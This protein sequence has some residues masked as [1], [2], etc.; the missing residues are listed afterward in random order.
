MG[1]PDAAP[2]AGRRHLRLVEALLFAAPQPL[3]VADIAAR[4]PDDAEP[5]ALLARLRDH[6]RDRGVILIET[7][8]RWA[9]RT[10]PDLADRLQAERPEQRRLSRAAVETLAIIAYHQPITRAEIEDIRGVALSKGT[11]DQLLEAGWI[12]PRGRR[13]SP[14]RPLTWGTSD[15]F[16]DHFGLA[17]LDNLPGLEELKAA[18]LLDSRPALAAYGAQAARPDDDALEDIEDQGSLTG[19]PGRAGEG[20][21]Q[22][23]LLRPAP[24]S[25]PDPNE[26][27]GR[28]ANPDR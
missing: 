19:Q 8:G 26:E 2:D 14:G 23:D 28:A 20:D 5:E 17:A 22:L 16:L 12:R 13:Q 3:T 7:G 24:T 25:D 27:E 4:L 21:A 15:G 9:F 18:G 6:Y 1:G 10:A 11:L